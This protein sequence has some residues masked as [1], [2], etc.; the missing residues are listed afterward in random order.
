MAGRQ[1]WLAG[2][3]GETAEARVKSKAVAREQ[4]RANRPSQPRAT[5][6]DGVGTLTLGTPTAGA[7]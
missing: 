2:Q 4:I 5:H 6:P 7:H 1:Q 3:E